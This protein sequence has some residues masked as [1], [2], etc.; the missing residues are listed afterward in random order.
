MIIEIHT[1]TRLSALSGVGIRF[2]VTGQDPA[3]E[4]RLF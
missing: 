4:Q 3:N 2:A 1:D